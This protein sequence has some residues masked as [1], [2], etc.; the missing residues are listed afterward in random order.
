MVPQ[1]PGLAGQGEFDRF[2]V[3]NGLKTQQAIR[4]VQTNQ[5]TLGWTGTRT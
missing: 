1:K 4:Q 3:A 2:I 5:Q